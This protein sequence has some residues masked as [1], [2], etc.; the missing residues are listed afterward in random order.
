LFDDEDLGNTIPKDV[1]C[2]VDKGFQGIQDYGLKVN[3][4]KKKPKGK[5]LTEEEKEQNK[6]ISKKRI[7][8]EHAIGGVKRYG[9][10]SQIYRNKGDKF[11]DE[12][13]VV[14]SGLWN[15]HLDCLKE[16]G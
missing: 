11:S 10:V 12:F 14:S 13:A 3:I 5:E 6:A 9:A 4:P 16:A 8:N 2:N 7:V 1:E 15:F